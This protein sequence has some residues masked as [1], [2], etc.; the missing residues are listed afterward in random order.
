MIDFNTN[1]TTADPTAADPVAAELSPQQQAQQ[2][3]L[4]QS[5][6]GGVA[7]ATAACLVYFVEPMIRNNQFLAL[8]FIVVLWMSAL[9]RYYFYLEFKAKPEARLPELYYA[10]LYVCAGTW[11]FY[12]AWVVALPDQITGSGALT[13]A[14]TCGSASVAAFSASMSVR[15]SRALVL[16]YFLP[17]ICSQ[18]PRLND[19]LYL[20]MD[21]MFLILIGYQFMLIKKQN[22]NYWHA[23]IGNQKLRQQTQALE[24]SRRQQDLANAELL[25]ARNEAVAASNAKSEFLAHISHEIRTPLNG[26]IG[27]ADLLADTTM[28]SRQNE[29]VGIILQSGKLVLGLINDILD[30]SQINSGKIAL[31]SSDV[32]MVEVATACI[33]MLKPLAQQQNN[34]QVLEQSLGTACWARLDKLRI[35][36]LLT[37]L[38][39]NA[40]K[41]TNNGT[42]TLRLQVKAADSGVGQALRI[43]IQDSGI[44]ISAEAQTKIFD[45]FMQVNKADSNVRGTGLG[46]AICTKLVELMQ[47]NIGVQS[48]P[49]Q[50]STFWIEIPFVASTPALAQ[51]PETSTLQSPLHA[52]LQSKPILVVED[53]QVNQKV[54]AAFLNKL[55]FPYELADSGQ[56]G[57]AAY[58]RFRP[59]IV[60][61]DCNLPD[62]SGM[63]VTREIRKLEASENTTAS[64]IIAFTAHAFA[65]VAQECLEAGMN[66]HLAK[67]VTFKALQAM[68]EKWQLS[69]AAA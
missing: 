5:G 54:I 55:Q 14:M 28:D 27:M 35:Q 6:L 47:G 12:A 57:L 15:V 46:L 43:E 4:N 10:C 25:A 32:D 45:A 2:D 7:V 30:F 40:H 24:E 34:R 39:S 59:R 50:G 3:L 20:V 56:L 11:G 23:L 63:D 51:K 44:G 31:E 64:T 26:V 8:A 37:N 49:G 18:I 67:P 42:V 48:V 38:V 17:L 68:L 58:Q 36:Q 9:L 19:P 52:R 16:L 61:M 1:P 62:M 29:Q 60:L 53:N 13:I 69:A 22:Y 21:L 41:F 33:N 65:N 66:D